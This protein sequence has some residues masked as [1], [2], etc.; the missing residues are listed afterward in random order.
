MLPLELVGRAD[1]REQAAKCLADVGLGARLAHYP[2]QLSGGEQQRVAIARAFVTRPAVL[3]ADEPTGNLDT[4]TGQR[5]IDLLVRP[6]PQRRQHARARDPRSGAR[7]ALRPHD[8]ARCRPHRRGSNTVQVL[9]FRAAQSLARPQVRRNARALAA[10]TVAVLSLTA[11]GFFTSRISQGVRAKAGEVLAADLRLE[12]A[13]PL[14][15]RY[16]RRRA[17]PACAPREECRS[18]A[19]CSTGIEANWRP[20]TP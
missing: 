8:R 19:L 14:P 10:L 9:R 6:E 11:V 5:I 4:S 13:S 2:K 1:A 16:S 3:F 20:C 18:R 12:S 17:R 15:P 7:D